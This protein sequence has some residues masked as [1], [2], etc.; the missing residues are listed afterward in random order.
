MSLRQTA[1]PLAL[2]ILVAAC[3]TPRADLGEPIDQSFVVDSY[4]ARAVL[5]ERSE[6]DLLFMV[7]LSGGGTRAAAM[8]TG[9]LEQLATDRLR[10]E[11]NHQ[12]LIDEIDI[13]SAV[14][15]GAITAAYYALYGDRVFT[16][17]SRHFLEQDITAALRRKILWSPW[18]W[19]RLASREYARGDLYAEY[20]DD[21]L[22][23][24]ARFSNL[25]QR[26]GSP[27][28]IISATDVAQGARFEFTQEQFDTICSRL[29]SFSLSRAVAAS[30]SVPALLTPITLRNHSDRCKQKRGNGAQ[31]RFAYLHLVDGA[32]SD[33]LGA[34]ALLDAIRDPADRLGLQR[35]PSSGLAPKIAYI[36]VNAGDPKSLRVGGRRKPPDALDMLRLMGT[37]PV[38][39]YT[40]ETQNL[41]QETLKKHAESK[42]ATLYYISVELGELREDEQLDRL[43]ELPTSFN[44]KRSDVDALRCAARQLLVRSGAY[45]DLLATLGGTPPQLVSRC[46]ES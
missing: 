41:L 28:L 15:G 9:V 8:A 45:R 31:Y 29:E 16:D 20:L 19:M 7:S 35:F 3:S 26:K 12:R 2:T 24:G 32:L 40:A 38:D 5:G 17:F 11:G 27:L 30:S 22:F 14:S 37:V 23:D 42:H 10:N 39:H 18:G 6:D 13:I 4:R 43:V 1:L 36:S 34:R 33:N 44:L 25:A 46:K 21:Q